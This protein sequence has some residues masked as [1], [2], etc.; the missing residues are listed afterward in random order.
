LKNELED[1]EYPEAA[2]REAMAQLPEVHVT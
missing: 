1:Y 2:V